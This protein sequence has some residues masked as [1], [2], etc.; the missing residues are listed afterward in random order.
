MRSIAAAA[1]LTLIV[2]LPA[3]VG[4]AQE[5]GGKNVGG[6]GARRAFTIS[7]G[8]T[9][10][11]EDAAK[12]GARQCIWENWRRKRPA[13]CAVIRRNIEGEP[14]TQNFYVN[15]GAGGRWQVFLE[16]T[17]VCCWYSPMEGKEMKTESMGTFT[18]QFVERV[19]VKNNRLIPE[20][21]VRRPHTYVLRFR[22]AA[23]DDD[24]AAKRVLL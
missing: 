19:D 23:T 14:T 22:E 10:D 20:G 21:E 9:R 2:A 18:Y 17:Y 1:M 8:M 11:E 15:R 13:H 4:A 24:D 5:G 6:S 12:E 3:E 16:V 7:Y